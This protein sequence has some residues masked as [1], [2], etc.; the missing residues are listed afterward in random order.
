MIGVEQQP[1]APHGN[2]RHSDEDAREEDKESDGKS[3]G[4]AP[5][6]ALGALLALL[7]RTLEGVTLRL[8]PPDF[9]GEVDNI[10]RP[11]FCVRSHQWSR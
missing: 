9:S 1:M 6:H 10:G 11:G 3:A 4:S 7:E 8:Q 2:R 5:T